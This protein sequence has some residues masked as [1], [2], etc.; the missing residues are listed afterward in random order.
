[1]SH[2]TE[3]WRSSDE[4]WQQRALEADPDY[5][6]LRRAYRKLA[7]ATGDVRYSTIAWDRWNRDRRAAEMLDEVRPDGRAHPPVLALQRFLL[8]RA[9]RRQLFAAA[10]IT[11]A[12]PGTLL[13]NLCPKDSRLSYTAMLQALRDP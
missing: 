12:E 5:R 10:V 3:H 8:A 4:E 6:F 2:P 9:R 7:F 13:V 1:M 11:R